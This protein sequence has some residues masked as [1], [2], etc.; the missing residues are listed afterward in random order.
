M[1]QEAG[2]AKEADGRSTCRQI[3]QKTWDH[4]P[5]SGR[6]CSRP[7]LDPVQGNWTVAAKPPRFPELSQKS[8]HQTKE[9]HENSLEREN[10]LEAEM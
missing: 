10:S 7:L 1:I 5:T 3:K 8:G 6:T 9:T 2:R 4:E